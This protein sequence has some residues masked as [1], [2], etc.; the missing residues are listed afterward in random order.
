M[1]FHINKGAG[2]SQ[3]RRLFSSRFFYFYI[4]PVI[5]GEVVMTIFIGSTRF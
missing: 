2:D 5:M 1:T 3:F 4:I